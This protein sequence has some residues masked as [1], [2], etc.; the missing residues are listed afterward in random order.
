MTKAMTKPEWLE[1][2]RGEY[3]KRTKEFIK[4]HGNAD[5]RKGYAMG[6]SIPGQYQI[7]QKYVAGLRTLRDLGTSMGFKETELFEIPDEEPE[8]NSLSRD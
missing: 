8:P 7:Q 1:F 6:R 3:E 4:A 5:V 2:L